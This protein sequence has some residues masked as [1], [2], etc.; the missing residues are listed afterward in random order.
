MSSIDAY[1]KD[2]RNYGHTV[3]TER[4]ETDLDTIMEMIEEDISFIDKHFHNIV[5]NYNKGR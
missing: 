5:R 2:V 3:R 1:L 4:A